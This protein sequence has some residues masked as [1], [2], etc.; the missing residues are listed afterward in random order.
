MS[1]LAPLYGSPLTGYGVATNRYGSGLQV[2]DV[3]ETLAEAEAFAGLFMLGGVAICRFSD[4]RWRPLAD[5]ASE[6]RV[7]E[8][9][10]ARRLRLVGRPPLKTGWLTH[11]SV[12]PS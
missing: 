2:A 6:G 1:G 12:R 4:G 9:R 8:L 10:Q 11:G 3:F 5:A 7:A